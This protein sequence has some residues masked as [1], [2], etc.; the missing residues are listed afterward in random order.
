MA[1]SDELRCLHL[2]RDAYFERVN[3]PKIVFDNS[4]KGRLSVY[5]SSAVP[6]SN[7]ND[8][9]DF[10]CDGAILEHFVVASS[11][12]NR[13]G[14][15]FRIEKQT[16]DREFASCL[17]SEQKAFLSSDFE[18]GKVVAYPHREIYDEFT[19][20]YF[21]HSF[22]SNIEKHL[23]S[24]RKVDHSDRKVIFLL[25]Q[26]DARLHIEQNGAFGGFY[27]LSKDKRALTFLKEHAEDID[28][29]IYYVSDAI[30][31]LDLSRIVTLLESSEEFPS[32][33]GGRLHD[34]CVNLFIDYL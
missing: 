22:R 7:E 8:F 24:L 6:N 23:N 1:R 13:K 21:F 32:I 31:I 29:L 33:K 27:L 4:E 3:S 9:P 25:E 28:Y 2:V 10:L 34:V 20:D 5:L 11:K 14:S 19:Y 26:Q 15:R 17:E 12:Q 16:R 30:E 18:K